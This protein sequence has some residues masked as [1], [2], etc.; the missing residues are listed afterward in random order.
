MT[1]LFRRGPSQKQNPSGQGYGRKTLSLIGL[2]LI[3]GIGFGVA[4][5]SE[6]QPTVENAIEP[7]G[8]AP[9]GMVWIPGGEFSMGTDNPMGEIC[10]GPDPMLDAQPIHRVHVDAF[11]IDA[12]EVTNRQFSEFVA[13]TSYVT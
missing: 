10:G 9:A 1:A 4:G 6:Y 11:W 13:A 12:T 7:A 3:L 8:V 5:A 2:G